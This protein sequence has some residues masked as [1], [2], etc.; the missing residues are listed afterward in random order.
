MTF[1]LAGK[2]ALVTGGSSGIGR[3]IAL[4]F[5]EAGAQVLI[6]DRTP[7]A[8]DFPFVRADVSDETEVANAFD[9]AVDRLG[10]LDIAV[11][12]A[13]IQPLGVGFDS[14]T[15]DLLNRTFGVNVNGVAFGIKH[16]ARVL[17]DG[18]RVLNTASFVGMIGTPGGAA[19]STSK[20]AV[21]HLTRLGAIELA[22]R[23]I[24]VNAISPGT[25]RTPA[26]TGIP[27][28]PEIPFIEKRTPLG[29]LGEPEEVAALA[30]FL[31]SDEAAYITGQNIAIDGGL[32]AGWTDYDLVLPANVR[33]GKWIDEP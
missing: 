17:T 2:A 29:R 24:T 15:G 21:I 32:T 12:N 10:K 28:N 19:Y 14:V 22:I 25:I 9:E 26:V 31:A 4:R 13:G 27:D 23:R 3:A 5:R 7:T 16:A 30:Q 6:V 18:G 11:N 8:D 1:S 33:E 20:A